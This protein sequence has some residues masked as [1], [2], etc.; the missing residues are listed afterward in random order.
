[1]TDHERFSQHGWRRLLHGA[2]RDSLANVSSL[3]ESGPEDTRAWERPLDYVVSDNQGNVGV[4]EFVA[5]G[6]IAAMIARSP[7]RTFD[8]ESALTR[9]PSRWRAGLRRLCELPLLTKPYQVT[10]ILWTEG[11][12]LAGPESWT[13]VWWSGAEVFEH[14]LMEDD[15]WRGPGAEYYGVSAAVAQVAITLARRAEARAPL[16][17]LTQFELR[18]L[19]PEHSKHAEAAMELLFGQGMFEITN[20]NR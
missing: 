19:V 1:M 20:A 14:E 4:A 16:L 8:A 15:A 3:A 11:D 12:L 2:V 17:R 9:A 13:D 10:G 18:Q 7:S 5:D 6:A